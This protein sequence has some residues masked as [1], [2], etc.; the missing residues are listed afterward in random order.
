[1]KNLR[2]FGLVLCST[3]LVMSLSGCLFGIVDLR[4]RDPEVR[5]IPV[6][7]QIAPATLAAAL[8]REVDGTKGYKGGVWRAAYSEG[9]SF[10]ASMTWAKHELKIDVKVDE[11]GENVVMA[12]L[13]S[14]NL[15]QTD[16]GK[17]HGLGVK[18]IRSL[19]KRLQRS[20]RRDAKLVA[21]GKPMLT[22]GESRVQMA[23]VPQAPAPPPQ[24]VAPP[25][26][27]Y[28]PPPQQFAA[29]AP[30]PRPVTVDPLYGVDPGKYHALVIGNN[31]Y[32]HL[33]KL[34]TA[35][36]DAAM[37]ASVLELDYGFDVQLITDG[38][39]SSIVTALNSYRRRLGDKE[40]LLIFYAGHGWYDDAAQRGYW[41][42]VDSEEGDPSN[43]ISNATI[44]DMVRAIPAK[45]VMIVAD[46]CYSGTLTRGIKMQSASE[47]AAYLRRI[48]EKKARTAMTSGGLEPVEDGSG[49]HSVFATAL[50]EA[51]RTNNGSIDAQTLF[52]QIRRPVMVGADQTP[53]YGD[54]RRAGHE[55]G[56]FLFV[57]RR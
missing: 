22:G 57:R 30:P 52:T 6:E 33:P 44:T 26:P 31:S 36:A 32:E 41:L 10:L 43:W 12:L 19:H 53:E 48:I 5:P 28:V 16:S 35:V 1:M 50:T 24:P 8:A 25:R 37:V 27:Q 34:R 14:Q 23:A 3:L 39:R 9:Q 20:L 18:Q 17:I 11:R 55:G 40:N 4:V 7:F 38:D 13:E 29:P 46:S 51:L 2:T 47:S 56:D 42:P 54:I 49:N 45:H 15:A 21:A